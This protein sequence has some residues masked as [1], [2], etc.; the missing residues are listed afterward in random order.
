M[1]TP[2]QVWL[3]EAAEA[4]TPDSLIL[5]PQAYLIGCGCAYIWKQEG[6][7]PSLWRRSKQSVLAGLQMQF[8]A[9]SHSPVP[10]P[11]PKSTHPSVCLPA[12]FTSGGS[13]S[14]SNA[15]SCWVGRTLPA[16]LA[17]HAQKVH[18]SRAQ[19]MGEAPWLPWST[20]SKASLFI[21][22]LFFKIEL[23]HCYIC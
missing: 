15:G 17:K 4:Q 23:Y 8:T 6:S 11:F 14:C 16:S 5:F 10:P 7:E 13:E 1:R 22:V 20:L 18:A 3:W 9:L 21:L 19:A 12:L 2:I